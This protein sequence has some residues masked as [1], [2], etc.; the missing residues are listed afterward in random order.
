MYSHVPQGRKWP[1]KSGGQ[2]VIEVVV[3]C[4]GVAGGAFYKPNYFK[5]PCS[6][7]ASKKLKFEIRTLT[8]YSS[9]SPLNVGLEMMK[10][11]AFNMRS[12][13]AVH[14]YIYG[15]SSFKGGIQNQKDSNPKISI[16]K[17]NICFYSS[18]GKSKTNINICSSWFKGHNWPNS[19]LEAF[20]TTG[21]CTYLPIYVS[22]SCT[23]SLVHCSVVNHAL[24]Q[25]HTPKGE[26]I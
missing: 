8:W 10:W 7:I 5:K 19:G 17:R 25:L 22:N 14:G 9:I 1:P 15:L 12:Y 18:L 2:V 24:P 21:E 3:R 16:L 11:E 26:L 6:A 23:T 13:V 20:K 4:G